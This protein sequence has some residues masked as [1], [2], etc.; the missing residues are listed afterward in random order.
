MASPSLVQSAKQWEGQV[1]HGRFALQRWLGGS[2]HSA[3]FLTDRG[4]ADGRAAIKFIPTDPDH[5]EAQLAQWDRVSRLSHPHLL[6][7]FH[8]GRCQLS[9]RPFLYVV[10]E[11][12]EEDLSQIVP[13]RA[14]TAAETGE[15]LRPVLDAMAYVHRHAL[16]HGHIKPANIMAVADE[17]KISSDGIAAAGPQMPRD[18]RQPLSVYDAPEAANGVL[19]SEADQWS[20][21]VTLIEV[22]TQ[23]RPQ[24]A[25]AGDIRSQ[26]PMGLPQPYLDI[27]LHCLREVP[28]ERW[29][30]P[31]VSARIDPATHLRKQ[32]PSIEELR[33]RLVNS[34]SSATNGA[35][36]YI[37]VAVAVAVILLVFVGLKVRSSGPRSSAGTPT[38]VQGMPPGSSEQVKPVPGTPSASSGGRSESASSN[39][40]QPVTQTPSSEPSGSGLRGSETSGPESSASSPSTASSAAPASSTEAASPSSGTSADS[41]STGSVLHQELPDVPQSARNTIEGHVRVGVRVEVDES[42]NVQN[43]RLSSP[44]PSKYFARLALASSRAWKFAPPQVNGHAV[45]SQWILK[46]AF[47][48]AATEVVPEQQTR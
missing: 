11:F 20:L 3:V 27:V 44:G 32:P 33:P 36:P 42:G 18:S 25:R 9:G 40:E 41:T 4:G 30:V 2:E 19:G 45:A 5:A 6:R 43:A 46:Y 26:I 38:A 22:L 35:R 10:T 16:L 24:A 29:S 34:S 28:G 7:I 8:F 31:E 13:Q 1:I 14:L 47:G 12:A 23:R 15:M 17:L 48:R 39:A 21:G 37:W